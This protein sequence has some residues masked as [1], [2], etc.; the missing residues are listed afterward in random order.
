[1]ICAH[2][3]HV[4]QSLTRDLGQPPGDGA[5]FATDAGWF[6]RLG[7]ECVLYG[8]GDIGVAHKPNEFLPVSE[9]V[10]CAN[11]I[12]RLVQRFCIMDAP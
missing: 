7:T 11:V 2:N 10:Q 9:F 12:A 1:M 4:N 8:P 6:Q 3:A 5:S